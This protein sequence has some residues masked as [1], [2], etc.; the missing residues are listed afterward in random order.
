[1]NLISNE[2]AWQVRFF[3]PLVDYSNVLELTLLCK[4]A[5]HKVEDLVWSEFF[6]ARDKLALLK[7]FH[8]KQIRHET[9]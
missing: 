6:L 4:D 3:L 5:E 7:Q 8:V 2:S 9:L 1:M